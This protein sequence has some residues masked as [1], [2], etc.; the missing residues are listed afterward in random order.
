MGP[1]VHRAAVAH[2][3]RLLRDLPLDAE[4]VLAAAGLTGPG[5]RVSRVAFLEAKAEASRRLG[6][7]HLGLRLGLASDLDAFE[8][9]GAVVSHATT[10]RESLALG[11]RALEL[12]EQGTEARVEPSRQG[13]RVHYRN[14][15]GS[16]LARRVDNDQSVVFLAR[17]ARDLAGVSAR[18]VSLN[19]GSSPPADP[20][21]RHALNEVGAVRHTR[22]RW[23]FDVAHA[24]LDRPLRPT[25]PAARR[26][27]VEQMDAA[28]RSL[29]PAGDVRA[30]LRALLRRRLERGAALGAVAAEMGTSPRALQQRLHALGSSFAGERDAVREEEARELLRDPTLS[31]AEVAARVGFGSTAGFSRFFRRRTGEVASRQ[32]GGR[33]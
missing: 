13:V 1:T 21:L 6:D 7:P 27:L 12:W 25:H 3:Q 20:A 23:G 14:L 4:G 24:A 16:P 22:E 5:E 26:V 10:L 9:F 2:L 15:H 19:L 11:V 28:L 31:V 8:L 29:R 17:A 32:R 30:T 18:E 33:G